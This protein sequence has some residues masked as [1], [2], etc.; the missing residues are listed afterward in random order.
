MGWKGGG[1]ELEECLE[2]GWMFLVVS[3]EFGEGMVVGMVDGR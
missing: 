1:W 3:V 2:E